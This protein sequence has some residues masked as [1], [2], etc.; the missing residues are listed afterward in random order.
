MY[1]STLFTSRYLPLDYKP[2]RFCL[3]TGIEKRFNIDFIF[4][5]CNWLKHHG[6]DKHRYKLSI[7]R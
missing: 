6:F 7:V 2:P 3:F 4:I 5:K 1:H